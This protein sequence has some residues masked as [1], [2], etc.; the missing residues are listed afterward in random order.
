METWSMGILCLKHFFQ[1]VPRNEN[2]GI[3]EEF[4][5]SMEKIFACLDTLGL[6]QG[7]FLLHCIALAFV[8]FENRLKKQV[9]NAHG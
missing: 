6:V 4:H 5:F 8:L 1:S 7:P 3:L 9:K 2:P